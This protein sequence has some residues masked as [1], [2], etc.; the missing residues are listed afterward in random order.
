MQKIKLKTKSGKEVNAFVKRR[1]YKK[2]YGF[3]N[4]RKSLIQRIIKKLRGK[5][6]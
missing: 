3:E 4:R 5:E 1:D 6:G 2:I